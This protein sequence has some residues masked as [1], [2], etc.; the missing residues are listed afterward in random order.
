MVMLAPT[1][2]LRGELANS[3]AE[4]ANAEQPDR[5][6]QAWIGRACERLSFS[7]TDLGRDVAHAPAGHQRQDQA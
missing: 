1:T 2:A 3:V 5:E 4:S 6:L 7:T